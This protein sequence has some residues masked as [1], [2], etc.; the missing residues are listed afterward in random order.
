MNSTLR[1][2]HLGRCTIANIN[3]TTS[4]Q[5][6]QGH[7][8]QRPTSTFSPLALLVVFVLGACAFFSQ[9]ASADIPALYACTPAPDPN[10]Q[11]SPIGSK[12]APAHL[13]EWRWTSED[14]A[15]FS[16]FGPRWFNSESEYISTLQ[17]YIQGV[18]SASWCSVTYQSSAPNPAHG[19]NGVELYKGFEVRRFF[20]GTFAYIIPP[21]ACN[22]PPQFFNITYYQQRPVGCPAGYSLVNDP[23][24][25][26][27]GYCACPWGTEACPTENE[28]E[29][30]MC[31]GNPCDV[32]TGEKIESQTDYVRGALKFQR[33]YS[34]KRAAENYRTEMGT[35]GGISNTPPWA[36]IGTGWGANYFQ[37]VAYTS[38]GAQSLSGLMVYRPNGSV[39]SFTET[40]PGVFAYEGRSQY[41]VLKALDGGGAHIGW[42]VITGNDD[43]EFY[44]LTGRLESITANSG[45]VQTLSYGGDN[46]LDSVTD[47]FG[48]TLSFTWVGERLQSVTAP[49]GAATSFSYDPNTFNL[50]SV[51]SPDTSVRN[52]HYELT[53]SRA[54]LLTGI[55]DESSVRFTTWGYD[56]GSK[57]ISS[58]RWGGTQSFAFSTPA[59]GIKRVVDPLGTTRDY[60]I[61][62][63]N[64]HPRVSASPSICV[65]CTETKGQTYDALGNITAR[66]DFNDRLTCYA[67]DTV[68]SLETVRVEGFAANVPSCP[69]PLSSYLPAA[70]TRERKITTTWHANYRTPTSITESN[71]TT[72]FTHDANGNVLT[73]TVTDT[74]VVPNVARTWTYTYNSFGRVLTEDGP[75][76]DV[77]DVTTYAYYTCS[78]GYQ[79]GQLNTI[80]NAAGHVTTYNAYNVH[81]QPTQI[82][83]PNGFMTTL[84]YDVRQRLTDRCAGSFL[85]ACSGGELTHLDY[86]PTGLLKKATNPDASYIEYAYDG[87]HR[88]T[89]INDGANNKIVYTLDNAGNRT[90]ESSY[91][92]SFV[93]KRT[94]SRVFNTLSQLWKDVNAAG[95][96]NVTTVFG[97]DNNGNQTT[98][99]APLS[100]N[101][102]NAYDEL[103]RLKQ[104]TDP[105]S[106]V[107]QFG[108]DA[109]DNLTS[110]TDPRN[111]VD[112]LHVHGVWRSIDPD[113]PGYC[114]HDQHL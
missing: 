32:T 20:N 63:V 53:G 57:A 34:S 100:R 3:V 12:C 85:P 103:S 28:F 48:N 30:K 72:T 97:Y 8:K 60:T 90:A 104:I 62:F 65:G 42:K 43:V 109:N 64:A 5:F 51:T 74:S 88:L 39:F 17:S 14:L 33:L 54:N 36:P 81:G 45:V 68:R 25:N 79:C 114:A 86:W 75:R 26:S 108:Y 23:V 98:V 113:E 11:A 41:R 66:R 13:G 47:S 40:S 6:E 94:H 89:Q 105:A 61:K 4:V 55:T 46:Y 10:V 83:D 29:G 56:G 96:V 102:T 52:F 87:A 80:T 50:T 77:T 95:T 92:P 24:T 22:Y 69:V 2:R 70:G 58:S 99:N 106:G 78:T 93:L 110:V 76:T 73:R 9:P 37:R 35:W 71:R 38:A 16:G 112:E 59:S 19:A 27:Q 101:S 111:L 44:S 18:T 107:T 84:A 1:H 31:R 15:W 91:D 82:T 67:F 7:A 21:G 49:G